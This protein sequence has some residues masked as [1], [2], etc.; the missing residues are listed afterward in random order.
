VA[1]TAGIAAVWLAFHGRDALAARYGKDRIAEVFRQ[2]LVST[3]R[4]D[5]ELPDG[6]FGAGIVDCEAL[7][8]APLPDL[9]RGRGRRAR[10]STEA[11]V[12]SELKTMLGIRP[13]SL[14]AS[15]TAELKMAFAL[16]AINTSAPT[17]PPARKSNKR[18]PGRMALPGVSS[19]LR[20][21]LAG[22]LPILGG[23]PWRNQ[24]TKA[25]TAAFVGLESNRQRSE[26]RLSMGTR[27]ATRKSDQSSSVC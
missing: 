11:A 24:P 2:M 17:T 19:D 23:R 21:A 10:Q 16:G 25:A 8:K 14:S 9:G 7:L 1:L 4:T 26:W 13:D 3:A 12:F 6:E 22:Q 27:W 20:A 15:L 5:H 18:T